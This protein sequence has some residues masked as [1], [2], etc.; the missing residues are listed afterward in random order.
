MR[1]IGAAIISPEQ[2][3][4]CPSQQIIP[5]PPLPGHAPPPLTRP[6]PLRAAL[7]IVYAELSGGQQILFESHPVFV[8]QS[9]LFICLLSLFLSSSFAA[10]DPTAAPTTCCPSWLSWLCAVSVP[11]WCPSA[12][13]WRSS[14]TKGESPRWKKTSVKPLNPPSPPFHSPCDQQMKTCLFEMVSEPNSSGCD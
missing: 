5:L 3:A 11:S 9:T 12:P 8:Q 7:Y 10:S 2:A 4:I 1:A 13:L 6:P 14:F